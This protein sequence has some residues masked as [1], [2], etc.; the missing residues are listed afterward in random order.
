ME[1]DL[2]ALPVSDR[3]PPAKKARVSPG[4]KTSPSPSSSL[5]VKGTATSVGMSIKGHAPPLHPFFLPPSSGSDLTSTCLPSLSISGLTRS[6]RVMS[7]LG[8]IDSRSLTF[9]RGE[10]DAFFL[11]M[12][13]RAEHKWASYGMSPSKWVYAASLYNTEVDRINAQKCKNMLR[14]TPRALMEKLGEVEGRVLNRIAAN[15]Y[16]CTF[17]LHWNIF[18]NLLTRPAPS[19]MRLA[20]RTGDEKFWREHCHAVMLTKTDTTGSGGPVS[21]LTNS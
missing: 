14:K 12:R 2:S 19:L 7:V 20:K 1:A 21:Q 17:Y 13:L 10:S 6:Q 18:C 16:R 11:F 5:T 3:P 4:Q 9:S 8:G 15:D